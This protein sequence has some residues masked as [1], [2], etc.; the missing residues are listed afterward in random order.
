MYAAAICRNSRGTL[1]RDI[2]TEEERGVQIF[3]YR[4]SCSIIAAQREE[5]LSAWMYFS[6]SIGHKGMATGA[7]LSF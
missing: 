2:D 6:A 4:A 3:F 7:L 1:C 5:L